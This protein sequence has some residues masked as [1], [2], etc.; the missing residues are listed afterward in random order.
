MILL[1]KGTLVGTVCV[2]GGF[3]RMIAAVVDGGRIMCGLATDADPAA[4]PSVAGFKVLKVGSLLDACVA[5][6][7]VQRGRKPLE[8]K[9]KAKNAV[10][11]MFYRTKSNGEIEAKAIHGN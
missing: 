9:I 5:G 4:V 7:D 3:E 1:P 10:N 6:R 8:P 11:S 2:S